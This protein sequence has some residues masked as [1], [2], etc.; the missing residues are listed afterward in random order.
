[1][2][3][4]I[5]KVLFVNKSDLNYIQ[6]ITED[7]YYLTQAEEESESEEA[8][9][10][11]EELTTSGY[12]TEST[13]P[14]SFWRQMTSLTGSKRKRGENYDDNVEDNATTKRARTLP[15]LIPLAT[16]PCVDDRSRLDPFYRRLRVQTQFHTGM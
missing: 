2:I 11:P 13:R 15:K 16:P 12:W 8:L 4:T 14:K 6:G 7:D 5:L 10:A 3:S 9:E 1:M